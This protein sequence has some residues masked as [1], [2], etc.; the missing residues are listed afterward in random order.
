MRARL[1]GAQRR[2][3]VRAWGLESFCSVREAQFAAIGT[4]IGQRALAVEL[5]A[6]FFRL[7]HLVS[8]G[9]LVH[10]FGR[11]MPTPPTRAPINMN[12][13]AMSNCV[14]IRV[15]AMFFS[16]CLVLSVERY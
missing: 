16:C 11:T 13:S 6:V 7:C 5:L 3:L 14:L 9:G 10:A 4:A 2:I 12:A 15:V 1:V 8:A